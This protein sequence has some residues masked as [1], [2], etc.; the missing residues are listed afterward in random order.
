MTTAEWKTFLAAWTR[1][2]AGL[3]TKNPKTKRPIDPVHG[4]VGICD[5]SVARAGR[6][7]SV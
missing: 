6:L 2:I 4:S 7:L 3:E 1:E 5:L